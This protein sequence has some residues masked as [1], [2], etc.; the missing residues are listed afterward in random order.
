MYYHMFQLRYTFTSRDHCFK[1]ECDVVRKCDVIASA[2]A[3]SLDQLSMGEKEAHNTTSHEISIYAFSTSWNAVNQ[4]VTV[5]ED[6][7]F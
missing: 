7:E 4:F 3:C 6:Q 1:R 5:T 2:P